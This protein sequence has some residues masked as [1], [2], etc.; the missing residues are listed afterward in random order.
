M[1]FAGVVLLFTLTIPETYAPA[2]L[3]RRA[4]RLREKT[5]DVTITTEQELFR[6]SLSQILTETLLRPFRKQLSRDSPAL[7]NQFLQR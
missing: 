6:A 7:A 3:K 4:Q 2:L 1:I 5:G